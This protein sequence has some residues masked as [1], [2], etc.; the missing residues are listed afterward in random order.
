MQEKTA[1]DKKQQGRRSVY[2]PTPEDVVGMLEA[3]LEEVAR[4]FAFEAQNVEGG[5][6]LTIKG[7]RKIEDEKGWYLWPA[8]K[9]EPTPEGKVSHDS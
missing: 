9:T 7:V 3:G 2:E 4:H 1:S 6:V 5:V 8:P